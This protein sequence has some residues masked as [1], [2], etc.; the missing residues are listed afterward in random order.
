MSVSQPTGRGDRELPLYSF[1]RTFGTLL[2]TVPLATSVNTLITVFDDDGHR[3]GLPTRW[4][5]TDGLLLLV[6]L[7][8]VVLLSM[9]AV[10]LWVIARLSRG[11]TIRLS[12]TR[13]VAN[14]ALRRQS[15]D[16]ATAHL[17]IRRHILTVRDAVTGQQLALPLTGPGRV[18]PEADLVA[19]ADTIDAAH[20]GPDLAQA[21]LVSAALRDLATNTQ[22]RTQLGGRQ[23]KLHTAM[24]VLV[25]STWIITALLVARYVWTAFLT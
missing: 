4:E 15:V 9:A 6:L 3:V 7:L 14:A 1:E 23:R 17:T 12:G 25:T 5:A 16:I 18:L 22:L 20:P 13:L 24:V 8:L 11:S 10:L 19:L 2:M 21:G